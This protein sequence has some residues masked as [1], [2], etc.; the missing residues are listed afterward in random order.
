MTHTMIRRSLLGLGLTGALLL[1]GCAAETADDDRSAAPQDAGTSAG[2][3]DLSTQAPA[4]SLEDA[5]ATA[6][7]E[8]GAEAVTSIAL[9]DEDSPGSWVWS[10]E[11][12]E[13]S[14]QHEVDIDADSGD[15][16]SHTTDTEDRADPAVDP[17]ALP[18]AEAMRI[19]LEARSGTVSEWSLESDDGVVRYSIDVRDGTDD[20][21]VI[22]DL[23]T[24]EARVDD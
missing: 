24:R 16:L 23:Q 9:D 2:S 14:T 7:A 11:T 19:A 1:T 6:R 13:G 4:V 15:V 3:A 18:P 12:Y 20:V 22:V 5:L 17:D 8:S 10:I 21:E